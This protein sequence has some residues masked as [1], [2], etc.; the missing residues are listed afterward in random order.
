M[1]T[2]HCIHFKKLEKLEEN[3]AKCRIRGV[4][5]MKRHPNNMNK[6]MTQKFFKKCEF[7]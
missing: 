1:E 6:T 7:L 2:G 3:K 5:E 4:L